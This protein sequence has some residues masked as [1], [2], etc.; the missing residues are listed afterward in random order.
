MVKKNIFWYLQ[1]MKLY[2][3]IFFAL[4]FPSNGQ[5]KQGQESIMVLQDL[6]F[7]RLKKNR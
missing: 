5:Q 1:V 3:T 7:F 2:R 6:S 4:S